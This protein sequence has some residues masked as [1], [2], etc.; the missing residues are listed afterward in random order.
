MGLTRVGEQGET[1]VTTITLTAH[2]NP[3]TTLRKANDISLLMHLTHFEPV[4][5]KVLLS[6]YKMNLFYCRS[7]KFC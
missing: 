7:I 1:Q 6:I 2:L 4:V 3:V 5:K